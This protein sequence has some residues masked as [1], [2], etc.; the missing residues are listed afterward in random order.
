MVERLEQP[1]CLEALRR[2]SSL[3][4]GCG[5]LLASRA[6]TTVPAAVLL[7]QTGWRH[8]AWR[9]TGYPPVSGVLS[10]RPMLV[11]RERACASARPGCVHAPVKVAGLWEGENGLCAALSGRSSRT[12]PLRRIRFIFFSHLIDRSSH[13]H[14]K[15]THNIQE[16]PSRTQEP[17]FTRPT[18]PPRPRA[19][20]A[21][22]RHRCS[23]LRSAR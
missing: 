11:R 10:H 2:P 19:T 14:T 1:A 17:P 21:P 7:L 6:P 23:C 22:L 18:S 20:S 4:T 16:P 15:Y 9:G 13:H 5:Y 3:R 12:A 8:P